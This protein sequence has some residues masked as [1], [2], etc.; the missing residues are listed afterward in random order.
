VVIADRRA[1]AA[2]R[3]PEA[4]AAMLRPAGIVEAEIRTTGRDAPPG[5]LARRAIDDEGATFLVVAGDDRTIHAVVNGM[6]G[7]EGPRNPEAVLGVVPV[8]GSDF[9]RTFGL[10]Q[11]TAEAAVHLQGENT[12]P[13]DLGLIRCSDG[14]RER[15]RWFC[16]VAE[17]GFGGALI[18]AAG[19]RRGRIP[20]LLGFWRTLA[21]FSPT[22]SHV[23]VDERSYEG[24]LTNLVVA[25]GQFMQDGRPVAPRAHP[26]DGRFDVLIAKGTKR[27]YVET[28]T[29]MPKGFH[30]P[31]ATI[32]EYMAAT[33]MIETRVPLPVGADAVPVGETPA[34]FTLHP[35]VLRLK[36]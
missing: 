23:V 14:A 17:A 28:L 31:S 32:R 4:L 11:S 19:R 12:F 21:A 10:P 26:G 25:N 15:T 2:A 13:F 30:L 18:R 24:P 27:E 9:V 36:I 6:M 8:G 5:V 16:N 1:G 33:V 22:R 7:E 3:D 29:K 34:S 35:S 20:M